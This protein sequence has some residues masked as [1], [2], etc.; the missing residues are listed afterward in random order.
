MKF[1][2]DEMLKNLGEWL[3]IAGYDVLILPDGSADSQLVM[4]ATSEDRLLLTRDRKM[5]EFRQAGDVVVL[6]E[7]NDLESCV[8]ALN[9]QVKINWLFKPF[10]RC[11]ICNTLLHEAS[12]ED[13]DKIPDEA[14]Q[15]LSIARYCPSCRQLY[16]DGSHVKRMSQRLHRWN[17]TAGAAAA[18]PGH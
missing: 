2:C 5:N 10:S 17:L 14:R 7:C 13:R 16:W 1:L 11:K 9:R 18:G 3:R 4:R 12:K 8:A 6:L 15:A